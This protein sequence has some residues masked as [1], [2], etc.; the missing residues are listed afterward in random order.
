MSEVTNQTVTDNDDGM[1][2]DRWFHQHYP[3]L[4]HGQLQK[5]L[6]KGQV[7]VD[8]GRVKS[9]HRIQTGQD[10]RVPPMPTAE[11]APKKNSSHQKVISDQ[12]REFIQSL[13]IHRDIHVIVLNKPAGLAVQGGSG[14]HRHV[15]GMSAA[16][17]AK[18]EDR[19]RLVHRLD[20]DTS[21][22]LVLAT[23]ANAARKLTAAFKSRDAKKLYWAAVAGTPS[24][25]SGRIN[26]ALAKAPGGDSAKGR[27]MMV[28]DE[29]DGK[30]A[31][32]Y[33]ETLENAGRQ[34]AW[35]AFYP[36]TG[37]THQLRVHAMAIGHPIIGDGKY[38]GEEAFPLIDGLEPQLHLHAR[39][40]QI[41]HPGGGKLE[42]SAPLPDHMRR[43]WLSVGFLEADHS[44][45]IDWPDT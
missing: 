22:V 35:L 28:P 45:I 39:A 31:I 1:R 33:Y 23:N 25:S 24:P 40:I 19:P 34:V 26:L 43:T 12:D 7:R 13:V 20:K 8:G 37:R 10:I 17:V 11:T 42:V 29:T 30:K 4:S 16:L 14:T 2:I 5:M 44:T 27:E 3:A 32:T 15:D 18:D 41:P 38:G 36:V 6:R 9:N 21:G